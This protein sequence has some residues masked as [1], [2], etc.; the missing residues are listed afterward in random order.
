MND[1]IA[2]YT[3]SI[4][5]IVLLIIL[6]AWLLMRYGPLA[7]RAITEWGSFLSAYNREKLQLELAK[8][9]YEVEELRQKYPDVPVGDLLTRPPSRVDWEPIG[10]FAPRWQR[11]AASAGAVLFAGLAL[12]FAPLQHVAETPEATN[13]ML[14]AHAFGLVIFLLACWLVSLTL[15]KKAHSPAT[16][17]LFGVMVTV[18]LHAL[19]PDFLD[20][21]AVL[22]PPL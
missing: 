5:K 22:A 12:R 10:T 11:A 8:L 18:L 13:W 20:P 15:I 2:Q 19:L 7:I 4:P 9:R 14:A 6:V 16:A 17:A 1:L 3:A 21:V